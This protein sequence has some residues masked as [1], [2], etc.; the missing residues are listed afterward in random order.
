MFADKHTD[1][2]DI[3]EHFIGAANTA[4]AKAI[5]VMYYAGVVCEMDTIMGI[6][7]R[8]NLMFIEDAPQAFL[9]NKKGKTLGNIADFWNLQ[10][11]R[12]KK[13]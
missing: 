1:T 13:L 2:L 7:Q 4:K 12:N 6:T 9:V 8:Y 11:A 3:D 10:F 5:M